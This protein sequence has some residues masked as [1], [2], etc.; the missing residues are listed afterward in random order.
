MVYISI[1]VVL[2]PSKDEEEN[3]KIAEKKHNQMY[4]KIIKI[5]SDV[6]V[7]KDMVKSCDLKPKEVNHLRKFIQR[8][9][10]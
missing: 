3:I 9:L 10:N 4:E 6:E 7:L 5:E 2:M 1:I 8:F